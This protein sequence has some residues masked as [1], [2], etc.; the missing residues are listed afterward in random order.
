MSN[1]ILYHVH[2][3]YSLL[4][5]ATKFEEYVDLAKQNGQTAIASTEHAKP[6]GWVSK[7]MYCDKVG[8]KFMH[9]VEVYLTEKLYD[10]E[11]K[12]IRDNYHTVL[13]AKNWDGV[14]ELN[15]LISQSCDEEHFYYTNRITFDEFLCITDNIISTS[16]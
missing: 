6:L 1:Y 11:G 16:A 9:G 15:R 2:S 10:E 14:K 12:K 5:S 7:K 13:I 3:D 4:D 8:I